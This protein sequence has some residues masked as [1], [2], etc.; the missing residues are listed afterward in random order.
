MLGGENASKITL[1]KS[2]VAPCVVFP[3]PPGDMSKCLLT[4]E[5]ALSTDLGNDYTHG[6]LA[7]PVSLTAAIG[8]RARRYP[9]E[10]GQV[11]VGHQQRKVPSPAHQ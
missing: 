6:Q 2:T 5:K 11:T 10:H 8:T 7:K 1:D 4:P 3:P 9:Q